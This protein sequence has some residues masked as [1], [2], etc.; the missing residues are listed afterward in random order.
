MLGSQRNHKEER[1]RIYTD[2]E[3]IPH[4]ITARWGEAET[5]ALN[6]S[7]IHLILVW[8]SDDSYPL[9]GPQFLRVNFYLL[10]RYT[11]RETQPDGDTEGAT[12]EKCY[13]FPR[14]QCYFSK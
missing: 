4:L 12:E 3:T 5:L 10:P 1:R 11:H 9:Y 6:L 13:V 7:S 8:T 2:R 14:V